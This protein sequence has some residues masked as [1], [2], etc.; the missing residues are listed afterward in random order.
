[1]SQ[2]K[3]SLF[4]IVPLSL[5]LAGS[6]VISKVLAGGGGSGN[7]SATNSSRTP[8]LCVFTGFPLQQPVKNTLLYNNQILPFCCTN[9]PKIFNGLTPAKKKKVY[10]LWRLRTKKD[11]LENKAAVAKKKLTDIE[12]ETEAVNKAI[13]AIGDPMEN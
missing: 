6:I 4:V 10:D 11:A 9:C 8:V 5:L 2:V 13:N 12:A 7:S 3:K 1:M